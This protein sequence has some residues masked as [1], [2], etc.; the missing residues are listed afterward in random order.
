[1]TAPPGN[2]HRKRGR[3]V[4]ALIPDLADGSHQGRKVD[5]TMACFVA[6]VDAGNDLRDNL[7]RVA[8]L[9]RQ[10]ERIMTRTGGYMLPEDQDAL[11][12]ARALLVDLGK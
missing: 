6:A 2:G 7:E 12:A 1:M 3:G 8:T 4:R 9:L 5:P 11:R 10:L